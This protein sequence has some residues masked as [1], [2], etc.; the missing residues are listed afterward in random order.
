MI[1]TDGNEQHESEQPSISEQ[2]IPS[3]ES[4]NTSQSVNLTVTVQEPGPPSIAPSTPD[5]EIVVNVEQKQ[6]LEEQQTGGE[7]VKQEQKVEVVWVLTN[8]KWNFSGVRMFGTI[9]KHNL[10][11][12]SLQHDEFLNLNIP[13][14]F[15]FYRFFYI[16]HILL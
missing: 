10:K 5:Q 9:L 2:S 13:R 4:I 1:S 15:G 14:F 11:L 12:C 8:S 7:S 16:N 6:Q 3:V